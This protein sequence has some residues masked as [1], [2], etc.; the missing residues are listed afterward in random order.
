[1]R[2]PP[3]HKGGTDDASASAGGLVKLVVYDVLGQEIA[4]LVNE[5]LQPDTYEVE[6]DGTSYSSGIYYYV[7]MS[8]DIIETRKMLLIK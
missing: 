2:L 7:L 1:M 8:G 6:F 5:Q 4:T 3:F